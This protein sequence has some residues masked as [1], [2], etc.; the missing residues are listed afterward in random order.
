MNFL[1]VLAH[2]DSNCWVFPTNSFQMW[3]INEMHFM[4]K[5]LEKSDHR[6]SE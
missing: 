5:Y 1:T 2:Y 4:K 6:S 3:E